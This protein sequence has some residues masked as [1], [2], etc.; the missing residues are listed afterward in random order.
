[1]MRARYNWP[2]P[3]TIV[4]PDRLP[5]ALSD[6]MHHAGIP[7]RLPNLEALLV[8]AAIEKRNETVEEW[9]CRALGTRSGDA[10]PIAPLRLAG[11]NARFA[12]DARDGYWLCAD[13]IA[14]TMGIDSVRI[15]R[16]IDDLSPEDARA[17]MQ[18]LSEFFAADGLRF[19]A[20][21]P[22]RWYVRCTSPQRMFTMPL[23]RVIGSSMLAHLPRGDDALAWRSR[24][25]E[26]QM[27]LHA[28][29]VN[30]DRERRGQSPVASCWW[31]GGGRWP[32][33]DAPAIDAVVGGP[34]W[35]GVAGTE[36]GIVVQP[37]STGAI[38]SSDSDA[39]LLAILADTLVDT[40]AADP[41]LRADDRW[42]AVI[43]AAHAARG[44]NIIVPWT[45]GTLHITVEA[46]RRAGLLRRWFA[47][48]PTARP[49][50]DVLAMYLQ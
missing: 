17:I 32:R 27:L 5:E 22:S 30:A 13:P 3:L 4:A 20:P 11:E 41:W 21:S 34:A 42:F 23:S 44:L 50:T 40:P 12:A 48:P 9:L 31:W 18:T 37:F 47:G 25:N 45:S 36:T 35:V 28:H 10:T 39:R 6:S 15:D 49:I 1:M 2:M 14:A 24:L 16:A 7:L 29:P 38:G 8:G 26:A 46:Q 33:F 19:I 43:R